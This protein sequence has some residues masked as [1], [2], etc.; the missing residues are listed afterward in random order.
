MHGPWG[1]HATS[2]LNIRS[3]QIIL[4]LFV[5]LQAFVYRKRTSEYYAA[6]DAV[7]I[8]RIGLIL[9]MALAVVRCCLP[10]QLRVMVRGRA[11]AWFIGLHVLAAVSAAWSVNVLYSGYFAFETLVL[12]CAILVVLRS[13]GSFG[14]AEMNGLVWLLAIAFLHVI[15]RSRFGASLSFASLH[16]VSHGCLGGAAACYSL[17]ELSSHVITPQRKK[18]LRVCSV[19][20]L[21]LVVISTSSASNVAMLI[22]LAIVAITAER[23]SI[24]ILSLFVV[25]LAVM[26]ALLMATD[27]D[28]VLGAVFPG[29]SVDGILSAHGRT[30]LW[31]FYW[32]MI[33]ERPLLGW[34]FSILPRITTE[35][36]ATSSH[37]SVIGIVGG[38]GLA[39]LSLLLIWTIRQTWELVV[40]TMHGVPGAKGCLAGFV[41]VFVNSLSNGAFGERVTPS[42]WAIFIIVGLSAVLVMVPP[43]NGWQSRVP[44]CSVVIQECG[45]DGTGKA[46]GWKSHWD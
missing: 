6:V 28:S 22:G 12:L 1:R 3:V 34:G 20:G 42:S 30:T 45:H 4:F 38:M 18:V 41:V 14:K 24:R 21:V 36:Y 25:S 15:Y 40:C 16:S 5:L 46:F 17:A 43:K 11:A 37:N 8:L 44:G 23:R 33:R 31:G 10:N 26:G 19:L 9:A 35:L 27:L 39:G 29:K 2:Q 32:E 13:Y 7:S